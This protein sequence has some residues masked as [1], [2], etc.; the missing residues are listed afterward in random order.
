VTAQPLVGGETR[1]AEGLERLTA[2]S[3]ADV[4]SLPAYVRGQLVWPPPVDPAQLDAVTPESGPVRVGD[5]YAFAGVAVGARSRVVVVPYADPD[6]LPER[7]LTH[8][9]DCLYDLPFARVLAALAELQELLGPGSDLVE[10]V[11]S[12]CCD[13]TGGPGTD[14]LREILLATLPGVF[15]PRYAEA[16]VAAELSQ[17][18]TPG[19]ALLDGWVPVPGQIVDGVSVRLAEQI[20]DGGATQQP[21]RRP[22]ALLRAMPTRQL[23]VA[24]GSSPVIPAISLQRALHTKGAAVV[25]TPA[26]AWLVTTLLA[27][28]LHRLGHHPAAR[29]L[30]IVYW[31]GGDRAVEDRLLADG[32]FDRVVAWGGADAI[33]SIRARTSIPTLLFEPRVGMSLIGRE[34]LTADLAETVR[35]A[36]TDSMVE[37]QTACS[38][39]LVHYVEA[40]EQGAL[41]YCAALQGALARWDA[42]LPQQPSAPAGAMLRRLRR[43]ELVGARWFVNGSWPRVSSAVVYAPHAFDLSVHPMSRCVV[44]RRVDSLDD[45]LQ[46]VD[47]RV[48][49]A[50]VWPRARWVQLRGP[51]AARGVTTVAPL[52][53]S[54]RRWAGMP[55]DGMRPLSR[56]VSWTVA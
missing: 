8:L 48:S 34:A 39:S 17:P 19:S 49:A 56:L 13:E 42:A 22:A 44:V 37:N 11:V 15:D 31:R 10:G 21:G 18:G 36:T 24:A 28:A 6:G 30:S 43:V 41:D 38:S 40:D 25:K 7:D 55:H 33:A 35:R 53:E 51:L 29:H 45:A 26:T 3:D 16:A 50:G 14:V 27:L 52:G 9:C 47:R 20:L 4:L 54:E 23:H 46:H 12:A 32:A 5:A 2:Q 1:A